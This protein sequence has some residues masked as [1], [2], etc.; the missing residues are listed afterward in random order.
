[1]ILYFK[2]QYA[3]TENMKTLFLLLIICSSVLAAEQFWAESAVFTLHAQNSQAYWAESVSFAMNFDS[4]ES[5]TAESTAFLLTG[6]D[7]IPE[8]IVGLGFIFV[9]LCLLNRQ[10][11]SNAQM[12]D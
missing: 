12:K 3:V 9:S 1:M 4:T 5:F 8:P 11:N 7:E 10:E 6:I 2:N